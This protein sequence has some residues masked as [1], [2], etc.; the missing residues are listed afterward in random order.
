MG[1][2]LSWIFNLSALPM[3]PHL[4][5][6]SKKVVLFFIMG[7]R[8]DFEHVKRMLLHRPLLPFVDSALLELLAKEQTQSS[9]QKF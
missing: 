8:Q 2:L 6:I 3:T 7:L 9:L 1:P 4:I 5:P